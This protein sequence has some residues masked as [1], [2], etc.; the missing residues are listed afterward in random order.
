MLTALTLANRCD[1]AVDA[2]V[3]EVDTAAADEAATDAAADGGR[4][5]KLDNGRMRVAGR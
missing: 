1:N 2:G 3:D 4:G 5:E